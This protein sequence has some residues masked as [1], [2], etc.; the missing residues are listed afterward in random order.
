MSLSL[1]KFSIFPECRSRTK[2]STHVGSPSGSMFLP[3]KKNTQTLLWGVTGEQEWTP[4]LT[5]GTNQ[6]DDVTNNIFA[7]KILT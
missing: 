3:L 6:A 2:S 1:I 4:A 5:T 7:T